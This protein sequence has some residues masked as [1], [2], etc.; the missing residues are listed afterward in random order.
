V[1]TSTPTRQTTDRGALLRW[2]AAM[3]LS[4]T[5]GLAVL[6]SGAQA[7]AVAFARCLVGGLL[8]AVWCAA[9]GWLR[10]AVLR[11]LLRRRELAICI[12]GGVML[13]ANWVLL[14]AAY[15]Y[16]SISIATVV[17]HTQPFLL[18]ALA[19]VL[20]GERTRRG[21]LGFGVVAFAGVLLITLGGKGMDGSR[22]DVVGVALALGAA[23][24][25]AGAT[26]AA[27]RLDHVPPHL[28]AAVQCATGAVLLAPMLLLTPLPPAGSAWL[29]LVLLGAVHTAYVLMY[30]SLGKLPVGTVAVVSFLYPAVALLVDVLAFGHQVTF[31]ELLGIAAILGAVLGQKVLSR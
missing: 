7:P 1:T 20:L 26:L 22:V 25:Y 13:V 19:S 31:A 30:S 27:K 10:P 8:L 29:W 12:G 4:G 18:I 11:T 16:S 23:V 2:A 5:I 15:R 14:F 21:D 6:E 9:R 17:Y 3:S 24:L 28:V